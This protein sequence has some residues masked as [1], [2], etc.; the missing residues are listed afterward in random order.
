MARVRDVTNEAWWGLAV[1][2]VQGLV[3]YAYRLFNGRL[4]RSEV[5]ITENRI[6]VDSRLAKMEE[7]IERINRRD[8]ER[9]DQTQVWY[10]KVEIRLALI[11]QRHRALDNGDPGNDWSRRQR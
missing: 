1:L 8:S 7:R 11:E 4:S 10:G 2:I 9:S 5:R 3:T 6:E